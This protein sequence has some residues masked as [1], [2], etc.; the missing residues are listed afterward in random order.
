MD[1][2]TNVHNLSILSEALTVPQTLDD[3]LQKIVEMTTQLMGAG[4]CAILFRDEDHNDF[5]IRKKF[6]I[7]ENSTREGFPLEIPQRLKN[8]LWK[9]RYMHQVNLVDTGL[10]TLQF[11]ILVAPLT[12]KGSIIGLL[13]IGASRFNKHNYGQLNRE[14]FKLVASFS[15][16]VIENAKV[17][18]YLERSFLQQSKELIEHNRK[19]TLDGDETKQLLV[20]SV[21]NPTRTVQLLAESF[22]KELHRA[23]FSPGHIT[24][25]AAKI[26]D[27]ITKEDIF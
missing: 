27:C 7:E 11:P 18:D 15:S 8:I 26:L 12:V 17:Y 3:G 24:T 2:E 6:G 25:A 23:G 19:L 5:I 13:I 1:F 4:Q 20:N 9:M 14:L 16:L 10:D 22:Y 21:T